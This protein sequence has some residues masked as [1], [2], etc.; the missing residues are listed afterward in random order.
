MSRAF[1]A[2]AIPLADLMPSA[3]IASIDDRAAPKGAARATS[4][5]IRMTITGQQVKAARAV[6][7]WTQDKLAVEIRVSPSSAASAAAHWREAARYM[8]N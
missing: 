7:D 2:A 5:E 4:P 8:G 1:S 3:L 6:L